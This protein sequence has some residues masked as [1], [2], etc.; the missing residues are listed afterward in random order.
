M[1]KRPPPLLAGVDLGS[2][3]FRCWVGLLQRSGQYRIIGSSKTPSQGFAGGKITHL[4]NLSNT[5]GKLIEETEKQAGRMIKNAVITFN[6]DFIRSYYR[7]ITIPVARGTIGPQEMRRLIWTCAQ[8]SQS[9]VPLHIIPLRYGVDQWMGEEFPLGMSGKQL[10]SQ[11][12]VIGVESCQWKNLQNIFRNY[13]IH[14]MQGLFS[15]CLSGLAC[16]D[17]DEKDLGT[18]IVEL[19]HRTTTL[20]LFSHKR[21]QK[22]TQIPYGGVNLTHDLAHV[23]ETPIAYAERIKHLYGAVIAA[24]SDTQEFIKTPV[25]GEPQGVFSKISR[26]LLVQ[27]LRA[28]FEEIFEQIPKN[29]PSDKFPRR[30]ALTGGGTY[31]PGVRELAQQKLESSI[32][33]A[34]SYSLPQGA[35]QESI[36]NSPLVGLFHHYFN[37]EEFQYVKDVEM[38]YSVKRN[39]FGSFTS[40]LRK[41]L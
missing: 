3:E 33:L 12:H 5:L 32:R 14:L 15:G 6:G 27:I 37:G 17:P 21:V 8:E 41:N 38:G 28:R 30:M 9:L 1:L 7:S 18:W 31:M 36:S 16:L 34:S 22:I 24:Q 11:L 20:T 2:Y 29:I 13:H 35:P 25:L 39:L 26:D 19:G 4:E 23:L 40:W 10:Q